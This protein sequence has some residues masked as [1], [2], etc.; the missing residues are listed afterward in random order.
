MD[1]LQTVPETERLFLRDTY[2]FKCEAK[3]ERVDAME[4]GYSLV[5]LDRTLFHPQGGG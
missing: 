4:G 3:V 5:Y 2:L 1:T